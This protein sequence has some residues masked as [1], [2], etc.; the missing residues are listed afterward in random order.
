ML[1]V[2]RLV[3]LKGDKF[4]DERTGACS[5]KIGAYCK[6]VTNRVRF[7]KQ[8][9]PFFLPSATKLRRLCF[10]TCLSFCSQGEVPGHVSH[11]LTRYIPSGP[12]TPPGTYTPC[13]GPGTPPGTRYTPWAGTPPLGP[14]T[15]QDQVQPPGTRYTPQQAH[16]IWTRY[17]PWAGTPPGTRYT[18]HLPGLA[19][20]TGPGTPSK[21]VYP[22]GT[23]YPLAGTP[24][25][26]RY[27]PWDQVHPQ[28]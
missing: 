24:P 1:T 12:G 13:P 11:P 25:E 14:G 21:Q 9:L 7:A 10:Y 28:D 23:R 6:R 17:T 15:P 2:Y 20:P 8:S 5:E 27:S 26:T 16:P 4:K 3:E 19:T 22:H 18:P